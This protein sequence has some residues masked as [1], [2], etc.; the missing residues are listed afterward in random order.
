VAGNGPL[1]IQN[2]GKRGL[3]LP[4]D[5]KSILLAVATK[6]EDKF[7]VAFPTA[8]PTGETLSVVHT[9]GTG[10]IPYTIFKLA[11]PTTV[12][13]SDL[14]AGMLLLQINDKPTSK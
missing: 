3:D 12:S 10:K 5:T 6:D 2:C 1:P 7:K 14:T 8:T 13:E 11:N 9:D 4:A